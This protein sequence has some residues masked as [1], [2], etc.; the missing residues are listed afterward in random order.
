[1]SIKVAAQALLYNQPRAANGISASVHR[2]GKDGKSTF[3]R[4]IVVPLVDY[5]SDFTLEELQ[6]LEPDRY[7]IQADLPNGKVFTQGFEIEE[8]KETEVVFRIPHEGPHEWSSLHALTGQFWSEYV[9][10]ERFSKSLAGASMDY[11]DSR[12]SPEHGY[13]L[14]WIVP[15]QPGPGTIEASP[16]LPGRLCEVIRNKLDVVAATERLGELK[17]IETPSLWDNDFAIF[18]FEHDGILPGEEQSTTGH[19]MLRHEPVARN[20][21]VQRSG[22]GAQLICL[23][24]PWMTPDGQAEVELLVKM[25]NLDEALDYSMT[26]GEPMINTALGY[27][28]NGAIHLAQRLIDFKLARKMLGEKMSYPLSATVGGYILVL[29][30]NTPSYRQQSDNW[31]SWVRNLDNWFE[32][33]PD[34]AILQGAMHLMDK[35]GD[36]DVARDAFMRAFS[37]GLPFFTFGLKHLIDGMRYFARKDD[38]DA[39]DRLA[40]LQTIASRADPG[41]PFLSV[42]FSNKW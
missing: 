4:D 38:E 8:G 14:A 12:A 30:R 23:P 21:L 26:I 28:N 27:I 16:E 6:D 32:W 25:H 9:E 19:S 24:T 39:A 41:V 15:R 5:G 33:L 40:T 37:R 11:Q 3:L 42:Q 36:E 7:V 18:R 17:E 34:G 2:Q 29:G 20:Y 22:E 31:K 35:G 10:T 1:M 13:S